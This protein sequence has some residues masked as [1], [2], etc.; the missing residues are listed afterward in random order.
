MTFWAW[1]ASIVI[2]IVVLGVFAIVRFS[3]VQVAGRQYVA[4]TTKVSQ[5]KK[6]IEAEPV[7]PRPKIK[8]SAAGYISGGKENVLPAKQT[9]DIPKPV[10]LNSEN[11]SRSPVPDS[12]LPKVGDSVLPQK[13]EFFGSFTE[14]RKIC[15]VVDCSGSMG[16]VFSRVKRKLTESIDSLQ[17]DQYFYMLFFGGDKLFEYGDGR[18][19]RATPQAKSA[20]GE[21]IKSIQP[22]GATNTMEAME[23]AIQVR[24]GG[25][26]SPSIIYFL[27]DGFEL[28]SDDGYR[29]IQKILNIR[30]S[31]APAVKI[32]TIGFWPQDGDRRILEKIAEQTGGEFVY[33]SD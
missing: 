32:N 20:A 19:T 14:E 21:F 30:K 6:F 25:N 23:R 13:V 29:F 1:A 33:I 5:I 15:Y 28:T 12:V 17:P 18:L 24:D 2:H 7:I 31:F 22:A 27:T 26:K 10:L 4:P 8:K 11:F 16:G 3:Q 9:L